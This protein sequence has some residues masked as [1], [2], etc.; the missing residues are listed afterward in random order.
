MPRS[1]LAFS[2]LAVGIYLFPI[3]ALAE[4]KEMDMSDMK[5]Y[6]LVLL[7]EGPKRNQDSTEAA[8][9][10]QAHLAHLGKMTE[11]GKLVMAGPLLDDVDLRGIC[12]YDVKSLEEA[13]ALAEADP[14]VKAGR[15]KV[16]VHP[17]MTKKGSKLP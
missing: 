2:I 8:K 3:V 11:Q 13:K 10:Q 16:Q 12:I 7:M 1:V 5:T 14:A 4:G 15:L 17:W 9:I 6:Y